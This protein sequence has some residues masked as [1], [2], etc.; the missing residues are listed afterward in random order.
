MKPYTLTGYRGVKT[1]RP[2]HIF[3]WNL[4]IHHP[5]GL[6]KI[7]M[8]NG[9]K[10]FI[11]NLYTPMLSRSSKKL[12]SFLTEEEDLIKSNCK[13]VEVWSEI[14][15]DATWT[16]SIFLNFDSYI[17]V[18][19]FFYRREVMFFFYFSGAVMMINKERNIFI[20]TL[21]IFVYRFLRYLFF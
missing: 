21:E 5:I 4:V 3:S 20:T 8:Q 18:D 14:Q 6:L 19:T 9:L 15:V 1:E 13:I 7:C 11:N 2:T 10:N 16:A 17:S 12:Y